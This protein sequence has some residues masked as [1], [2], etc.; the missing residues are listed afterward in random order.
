MKNLNFFFLAALATVFVFTSCGSDD[1]SIDATDTTD[2]TLDITGLQ[3]LGADYAYEGWI[4]VNGDPVS[5]GTF[6]VDGVGVL[7]SND[8]QV[9]T[10]NADLATAF[11]VSI[12]PSPDADPAPADTKILGG[13][14]NAKTGILTVAHAAALGND[15]ATA[16]GK[17]ILATPSDGAD[18]NENS[19]LWFLD[20]SSGTAAASL[21]LAPLPAGWNYEGWAVIDGTPVSTGTFTTAAGVDASALFS[22]TEATPGYPGEDFLL[23]APTGFTFP[24]DLAGMTAVIS[25]EPSPDNSADPFVLKPLVGMIPAAAI[26]HTPYAMDNN[27]TATN[28]TGSVTI[29]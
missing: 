10:A 19:G 4:M 27:A 16:A 28:P 14:I 21:E 18:T 12:E 2:L 22:G 5:T 17:Y 23:N 29:K 6:T 1:D 25:I 15:F 26:D 3:N 24:V 11:I 9:S 20:N 8:F 13:A 7:T